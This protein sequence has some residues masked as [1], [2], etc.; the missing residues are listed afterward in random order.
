MQGTP[1]SNR[2]MTGRVAVVVATGVMTATAFVVTTPLARAATV[3]V[4]PLEPALGFNAFIEEHTTLASLEAE[5]GIATGGNLVIDG[6]YNVS[7]HSTG[8]FTV[9]GDAQPSALVAG[10]RI[11]FTDSG[12]T[13]VIRVLNQG[14]VKIGDLTGTD[15]HTTDDNGAQVNTR[16]ADAGAGYESKPRA[17]LTV[18][19][20]AASVG[21]VS[22]IDFDA[23]FTEFRAGATRLA[24]CPNT[25]AMSD[26][27]GTLV[28]EG[29]VGS[30]R[31][32]RITLE[33]GRT[34]VLN[35][36]GDDLNNMANS[37]FLN[38]PAATAPLLVNVDTS[39]T[40]G[41]FDWDVATQAGIGGSQAPFI[42][43]NFGTGTTAFAIRSGETVEGSIF[44]PNAEFLNL[45]PSNVEGQIVAE[46][47]S[48]G[49]AGVNGGEIHDLPFDATL[50]CETSTDP[51]DSPSMS[52]STTTGD[53]GPGDPTGPATSDAVT[54]S[55]PADGTG[56]TDS[57]GSADGTSGTDSNDGNDSTDAFDG[58]DSNGDALSTTGTEVG[59]LLIAAGALL[60]VGGL[61]LVAAVRRRGDARAD[62]APRP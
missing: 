57:P 10:G 18:Q 5:G 17:E 1:T 28:P 54:E 31:Q 34:N 33:E 2:T 8:S 52:D 53:L 50:V 29:E 4:D 22:P 58:T 39:G 27:N 23:A 60:A 12:A 48:L 24:L 43:W 42:L 47:A 61:V 9:D 32:I 45:S 37:T 6:L 62:A 41:E 44:A 16:I 38:P 15:V 35:V 56:D 14:Y 59:P 30:D 21:P 20:P 49:A 13:G 25:V 3:T 26:L 40:G 55:S 19:Q 36:T 51:T 7:L 46:R 11:D